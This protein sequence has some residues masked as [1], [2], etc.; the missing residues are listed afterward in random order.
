MRPASLPLRG[1]WPAPPGSGGGGGGGSEPAHRS[2]ITV[3]AAAASP[4]WRRPHL[5][6]ASPGLTASCLSPGVGVRGKPRDGG[7]VGEGRFIFLISALTKGDPRPFSASSCGLLAPSPPAPCCFL[8]EG[9]HCWGAPSPTSGPCDHSH[10]HC[11][12]P[13]RGRSVGQSWGAGRG[14]SRPEGPLPPLPPARG[15]IM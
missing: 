5:S 13:R 7:G 11:E 15:L 1:P 4:Q 2:R 12:S 8:G 9:C 3:V 6:A 14:L 10:S